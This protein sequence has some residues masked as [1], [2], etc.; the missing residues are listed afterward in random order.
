MLVVTHIIAAA[1]SRQQI[2]DSVYGGDIAD[3][4]CV[5][6]LETRADLATGYKTAQVGIHGL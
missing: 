3:K 5:Q 1:P 6:D 4:S 2:A